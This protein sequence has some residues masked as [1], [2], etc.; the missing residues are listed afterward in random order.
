V[1]PVQHPVQQIKT[2]SLLTIFKNLSF[3]SAIVAKPPNIK[4]A[5]IKP[6]YSSTAQNI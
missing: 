4:K 5:S 3:L 1:L 6:A 2:L